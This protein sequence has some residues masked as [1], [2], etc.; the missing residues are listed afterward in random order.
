MVEINVIL[1]IF[2]FCLFSFFDIIVFN[3]E[4]LLTLCFL[5]FLF[6]CFN[7][8]S[9][10]VAASFESRASKFED[11][12]LTTF[13]S[14][15]DALVIDFATNMKL[16]NTIAKF[17]ILITSLIHYLSI[18]KDFLNYKAS[19]VYYQ[20]SLSKLNELVLAN[21]SFVFIFQKDCVVQ[22]LYSLILKKSNN[23]LAFL[24]ASAKPNKKLSVLKYLS[25]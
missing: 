17:S 11:D 4:I 20:V 12:L 1:S 6:Y 15:K 19:W 24:V 25:L 22:L 10:S 18:S 14:S 5:A 16:Q 9:G 23:D 13:G 7:T 8:L 2:F 3:E 21:N